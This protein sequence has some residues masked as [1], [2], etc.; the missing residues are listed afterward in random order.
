MKT[1][2][3]LI[4]AA[5]ALASFSVQAQSKADHLAV[6][7][8][9]ASPTENLT[10]AELAKIFR[11]EK[12]K[13]ASGTKFVI[14]QQDAGQA[15]RAAAL[16]GIYKMDEAGYNKY[17]LQATFTGAVQAAPKAL[18]AEAAKKFVAANPGAISYVRAD[19]ADDSV[20]VVKVDGHAPG[21]AGYLLTMK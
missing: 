18:S 16:Q 1:K 3:T 7:V 12:A 11:A 20:K 10:A 15:A 5:V 4:M 17:F 14:I 2:H 6:I 8:A 19:E 9:K 21:E 13:D